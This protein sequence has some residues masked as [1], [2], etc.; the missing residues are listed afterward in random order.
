MKI[1]TVEFRSTTYRTYSVLAP[2]KKFAE[3]KAVAELNDDGWDDFA[4]NKNDWIDNAEVHSIT[5]HDV[6]K[7][8]KEAELLEELEA[9]EEEDRRIKKWN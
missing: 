8:I 2:S 3:E 5:E 7:V 1:Y 6:N 9:K 4:T